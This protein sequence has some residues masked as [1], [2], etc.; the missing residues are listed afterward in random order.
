MKKLLLPLALCMSLSA[1]EI[2]NSVYKNAKITPESSYETFKIMSEAK[3]LFTDGKAKD[4]SEL[5]IKAITKSSKSNA[6]KNIDQYDYLYAHYGLLKLLETNKND[7]KKYKKLA[8]KI[9]S[10]LDKS[11]N[12]GKDI[13]EDG[14]LGKFQ[15]NM[16]KTV[17]DHYAK[18]LYKESN[19]EDQK[20]LKE[21]LKYAKK[22]EKYIRSDED[23]YIKE[24]REWIQNAI[25]GNPPL[26]SEKKTIEII[27]EL[28]TKKD[29]NESKKAL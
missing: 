9:I 20:L 2:P 10:F 17:T 13:W 29:S 14:E 15:L 3:S 21:A 8:K 25:D 16:Y 5:F 22:A 6:P 18:L 4:A 27:K 24:T 28:K 7:E 12:N 19:R 26:K 23:F 11:T 1:L